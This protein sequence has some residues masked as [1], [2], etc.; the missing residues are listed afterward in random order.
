M[1]SECKKKK[2]KKIENQVMN[3]FIFCSYNDFVRSKKC[4]GKRDMHT[5]THRNREFEKKRGQAGARER[6]RQGFKNTHRGKDKEAR[7]T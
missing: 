6:H 3:S 1:Q 4:G 5:C 7:N 2:K